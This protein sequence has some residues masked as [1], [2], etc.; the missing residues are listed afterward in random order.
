M[1]FTILDEIVSTGVKK[2]VT[3]SGN[4][5]WEEKRNGVK[6]SVDSDCDKHVY[7][8][9]PVFES[10]HGEL[11]VKFIGKAGSVM[12]ETAFDFRALFLSQ[13]FCAANS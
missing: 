2:T 1:F 3:E 6:R 9:L 4:I 7:V 5:R 11:E 8:N 13:E 10:I 12:L